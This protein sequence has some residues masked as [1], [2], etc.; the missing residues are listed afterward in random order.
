MQK[1]E[2]L[3][4]CDGN[5]ACADI[6]YRLSDMAVIYPITPSSPMAEN[7]ESWSS[8]SRKNVFNR[9]PEVMMMQSEAGAIAAVH[10]ALSAAAL[11]TTFSSS[12]GLLL[13]IPNMLKIAGELT[14]FTM[15][16]A[17]RSVAAHALSI[18]GDHSDVMSCRQTGFAMLISGSVQ[19]A[20]DFAAIAH[21]SSLKSR[22]PF[23]HFFDGFR[24]S[25]EINAICRLSNDEIKSL[26][27][28]AEIKAFQKRTLNPDSPTIQG[29]SQNPD[30]FF[31]AREAV[32]P[33]YK[34]ATDIIKDK[35]SALQKISGRKYSVIEYVGAAD[36][37]HLIILMGSGAQTAQETAA[38]LISKGE[39]VAVIKINLYRPFPSADL[40]AAIPESVEKIAVL[41]KTKESGSV[42]EPLYLDVCAS[43]SQASRKN[44]EVIGGR[45]GLSSKDFTPACVKAVFD[46]LKSKNPKREFSV[47]ITDDVSRLSLPTDNSFEILED[48]HSALFYGLGSDGTVGAN[49]NSIKIISQYGGKFGQGYFEYDSKKSG[50]ITISHLRFSDNPIKAPYLISKAGFIGVSHFPIF[51]AQDILSKAKDGAVLLINTP[52]NKEQVWKNLPLE[53]QKA[54]IDKKIK[55]YG[56]NAN[57]LAQKIGMG[58]RTNTIMQICFFKIAEI[59]DIELAI[60]AVKES[61]EKTYASKGKN[62]VDMN[63]RAVDGALEHLFEIAVPASIDKEARHIAPALSGENISPFVR[64]V[65]G[66]ISAGRGNDLPVSAMPVDGRFPSG[67]SQYEKF[68]I[69]SE[70]PVWDPSLCI[71]CGRCSLFCPHAS[72]RTKIASKQ[73]L[74]GAPASFK[75]VDFKGK[76]LGGDLDF[77][78]AVSPKDCRGCG[79]CVKN[80]PG[81]SKSDG[82]K[83][84]NMTPIDLVLDDESASW[85]FFDKLPNADRTKLDFSKAQH[86]QLAQPLFEFSGACAG[87]GETPYIKLVTQLF[88][89]RMIIANATGC[90]SIYGGNLPTTPYNKDGCGRGPAWANSLFEDNAEF[91]Y[92]MRLAIDKK[93]QVAREL[94]K[95][96]IGKVDES[97]ARAILENRQESE[98]DIA[99]QR[100][101]VELLKK[102]LDGDGDFADYLVK[103]SVWII[104]G[105]GWAYDIGYGGLDHIVNMR[106]NV[107]ILVLDTEVYSNTGGQES[108]ATPFGASAKF[109][110]LG[111]RS[112]KKDLAQI[113]MAGGNAYVARIALGANPSQTLRALREAEAYEGPSV[114]IAYCPCIAHGYDLINAVDQES[115]AVKS[116]HWS[117]FRFDPRLIEQG[118]SGLQID[119]QPAANA[120]EALKEYLGRELRFKGSSFGID[121]LT[122][123]KMKEIERR[124]LL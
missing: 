37:K 38:R 31:Q 93:T 92:G 118:K 100:K 59:M 27:D 102:R 18:F 86:S 29:T 58:R 12:Q 39:K 101:N 51:N 94:L 85:D 49:K 109:A 77:I 13:M 22:I 82:R 106:R 9:M 112:H 122:E 67:T 119:S 83:A 98:A 69:A 75:R 73:S 121:E 87:C 15:H 42:G 40:I 46:E 72:I 14:P 33:Y 17:A 107:N 41:E 97:L 6:A 81:I 115:L 47:G 32:N 104:G 64:D 4:L 103:K 21:S 35:F 45:Y 84:I 36:A 79:I 24:T 95:G 61:I 50:A 3:Y 96:L 65:L 53:A 105:D 10:G 68:K 30:V 89:D 57:E 114:I 11:V 71:A 60:K 117:L 43:L 120:K 123:I 7:Y 80:C 19:E 48:V 56:I 23:L 1:K 108:K 26:L 70:I 54:I 16:V 25:H 110:S 78:V 113:L 44:I 55:V 88:G 20:H 62:I 99:L 66:V 90:S 8:K 76:D 5:E 111:R 2:N 116:G 28:E 91:G 74:Q 34:A 124:R 52:I 63:F